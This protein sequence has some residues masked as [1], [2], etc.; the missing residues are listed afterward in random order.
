MSHGRQP[1]VK[2]FFFWHGFDPHQQTGKAHVLTSVPKREKFNFQ[3]PSV[4][5]KC[6]HLQ[7]FLFLRRNML[8]T[9]HQC[10]VYMYKP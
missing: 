8:K 10:Y 7:V 2:C 9:D 5:H 6:H 4:A 3:L 1:E